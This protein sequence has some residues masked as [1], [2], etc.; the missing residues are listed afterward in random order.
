MKYTLLIS[1]STGMLGTQILKDLA[2]S[3]VK[4]LQVVRKSTQKGEGFFFLNLENPNMSDT[5]PSG[6]LAWI[7]L[8][9]AGI[10]DQHWTRARKKILMNSRVHT[11][12][13]INQ[14]LVSQN[15]ELN[16]YLG[17][18]ATGAFGLNDQ[19]QSYLKEICDQWE[20]AHQQVPARRT[21]MVRIPVI[22]SGTGGAM[23]KM[24]T[25][26]KLGL[27][28]PIGNGKQKFPW[29]H[30]K[31]LS[32]VFIHLM[33]AKSKFWQEY[34]GI[35]TPLAPELVNQGRFAQVLGDVL[36]RPAF[37]PLP[38]FAV[39]TLF[40]QMGREALLGDPAYSPIDITPIKDFNW[41]YG[42]L[43]PALKSCV[44]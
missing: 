13:C 29:I 44:V 41:A 10:A 24:I 36:N 17:A 43:K 31:D 8:N 28:G 37:I 12:N 21:V 18:S 20:E 23:A 25:P 42:Q 3:D 4:V 32:Q 6:P 1:G 16:L 33:I 14:V 40:G 11:T 34:T 15:R 38:S 27:G 30:I 39:K 7:N 19:P 9:G 5:L 26:F 22:L 35:I 2:D